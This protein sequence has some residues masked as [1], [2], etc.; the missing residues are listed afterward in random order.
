[1]LSFR[2]A[3]SG[4]AANPA[5]ADQDLLVQLGGGGKLKAVHASKLGQVPPPYERPD[6]EHH[7][8]TTVRIPLH[9]FILN[10]SGVTL[11]NIDTVR[12]RF[13][14]PTSGEIHVDDLEF[15]R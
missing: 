13:L 11:E 1:V 15:S 6:H 10:Q 14:N 9:S 3:Q 12:L 5:G 8:M 2:V 7:V 4:A